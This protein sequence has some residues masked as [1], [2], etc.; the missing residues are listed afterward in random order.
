MYCLTRLKSS[1]ETNSFWRFAPQLGGGEVSVNYP[2]IMEEEGGHTSY[3]LKPN[4]NIGSRIQDIGSLIQDYARG[5]GAQLISTPKP[6]SNVGSRIQDYGGGRGARLISTP[7]PNSN[8]VYRIQD[9]GSGLWRRK[10]GAAHIYPQTQ[11]NKLAKARKTRTSPSTLG[12][13]KVWA[14]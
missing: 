13:K 2:R 11:L 12:L 14:G 6:D 8:L 1:L 7:K 10:G 5:R 4:S 9:L 3:L